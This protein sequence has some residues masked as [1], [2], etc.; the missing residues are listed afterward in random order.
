MITKP[1]LR[2]LAGAFVV[3]AVVAGTVA[4]AS[5]SPSARASAAVKTMDTRPQATAKSE[6][7]TVDEAETAPTADEIASVVSR[8]NRAGV[9]ATAA[10]VKDLAAK[11]GVGGAVRVL[12]FAK[13]SGKSTADLLAA[14]QGGKGWGEIA[15]DLG[16]KPGIGW[17]M[18]NGHGKGHA[19]GKAKP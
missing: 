14:F 9:P 2:S 1:V 13:A 5:P 10:Q 8:L 4:A 3:L 18:S 19:N 17:I 6:A 15:H 12:W 11:V 7:E 16:L